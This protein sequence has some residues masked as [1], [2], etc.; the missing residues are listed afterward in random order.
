MSVLGN[1]PHG[2]RYIRKQDGDG[3]ACWTVVLEEA[4]LVKEMFTWVG[5]EG[6]SL[7]KSVGGWQSRSNHLLRG[8]LVGIK[9]RFGTSCS[10]R[11]TRERRC[12][13]KP[14]VFRENQGGVPNVEPQKFRARNGCRYTTLSEQ[15]P[16]S[17]PGIVSEQLWNAAAQQLEENRRRYRE[18]K[19]GPTNLLS[20]LLV[21]HRCGS[22]YCGQRQKRKSGNGHYV[23][24]RSSFELERSGD[25]GDLPDPQWPDDVVTVPFRLGVDDEELH[26][27][28]YSFWTDVAGHTARPI[29]EWRASIL[30]GPWFDPDLIVVARAHAGH[31]PIV[32][33][34]LGRT[35]TGDVGWVSQLGVAHSARGCGLGRAVLIEACRRLSR[36]Q[37]TVMGLGVEAD[38]D[39]ALGLYRSVGFEI[40][41]HWVHCERPVA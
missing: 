39:T 21:C 22:A 26:D 18:Q 16:I 6:L 17:V 37:P 20:G 23:P 32:G 7:G 2:Y 40:V 14:A 13:V 10:T 34:A 29:D 11:H 28:I 27:M 8:I 31:G 38:N 36:R 30:A 3:E 4:G 19:K 33:C 25:I 9:P 35:H 24:V 41:R 5:I 12:T 15:E 1:A